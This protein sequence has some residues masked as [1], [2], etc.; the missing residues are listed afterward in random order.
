MRFRVLY[1][2][3]STALA[4]I[5]VFLS[6]TD[7]IF[8]EK[9]KKYK[10]LKNTYPKNIKWGILPIKKYALFHVVTFNRAGCAAVLRGKKSAEAD[11]NRAPSLTYVRLDV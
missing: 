7:A 8:L 10:T 1:S 4:L 11:Q 9:L 2:T 5:S 3:I 6:H